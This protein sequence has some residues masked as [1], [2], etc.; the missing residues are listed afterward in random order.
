MALPPEIAN[1]LK[2]FKDVIPKELSKTLPQWREVDH[3]IEL[4]PRAK[5]SAMAPY[6]MALPKLEK[7]RRQFKELLD[8]W[9]IRSSKTP[10]SAPVLFQRKSYGRLCLYFD[11][12]AL[13]KVPIKKQ[14]PY[15]FSCRLV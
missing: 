10:Y 7:L 1:V 5:P 12:C 14:V 13:N 3:T 6:C 11:Y 8:G 4:E 2:D 9:M 15:S